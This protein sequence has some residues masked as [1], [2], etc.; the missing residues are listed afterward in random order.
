MPVREYGLLHDDPDL[1]CIGDGLLL[2]SGLFGLLSS[3]RAKLISG[4]AT[5]YPYQY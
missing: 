3:M 1:C 4:L 5:T 2:I